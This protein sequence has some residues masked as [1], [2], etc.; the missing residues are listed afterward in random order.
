[1]SSSSQRPPLQVWFIELGDI[2]TG[3]S[4]ASSTPVS[5]QLLPVVQDEQDIRNVSEDWGCVFEVSERLVTGGWRCRWLDVFLSSWGHGGG[6]TGE[7]PEC[8]PQPC[9]T[10][11]LPTM[12]PVTLSE[13]VLLRKSR[14]E[15]HNYAPRFFLPSPLPFHCANAQQPMRASADLLF[16][17]R[18][19]CLLLSA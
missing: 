8:P 6:P 16:T 11:P 3:C 15:A 5:R 7:T 10:P 9:K 19:I 12:P 2:I 1:M 4:L 18:M 17:C 13:L 14:Q